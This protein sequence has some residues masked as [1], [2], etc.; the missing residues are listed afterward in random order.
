MFFSYSNRPPRRQFKN[1][2]PSMTIQSAADETDINVMIARYQKTGSF[3]GSTNMPT[4]RPEF[5]D[6]IEVPDYQN[7]MNILLKAQDQFAALPANIRDR[8]A[9]SP[10]KY[11]AFLSDSA[12]KDEAIK[13]GL[14]NAPV[15]VE[16]VKFE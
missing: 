5:G 12:N 7:A 13:L 8:F 11:L 6:F 10:E 15:V 1:D 14:V 9:N 2:E 4:A 3:H 16:D